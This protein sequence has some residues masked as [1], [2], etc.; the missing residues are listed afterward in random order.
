MIKQTYLTLLVSLLFQV[1]ISAQSTAIENY[2]R[3]G[4]YLRNEFWR[5]DVFVK[6]GKA[7][8]VGFAYKNLRPEF[9]KTPSVMPMFNKA[10]RNMKISLGVSILGLVGT[11]AGAIMV[12]KSIDA[13][14]N[15]VNEDRYR[16]GLNLML[17]SALISAAVNIPLQIRARQHIDDA[18]WLR[19]R[20][21]L[22]G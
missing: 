6:D 15:L 3:E 1:S 8:P 16:N 11:T 5:G 18:I 12:V 10:Q 21:L 14:G 22:G 13:Q 9:E 4:I 7:R 20:T 2:D 19:N 17:E